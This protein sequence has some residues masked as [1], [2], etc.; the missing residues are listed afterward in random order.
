MHKS[1][2]SVSTDVRLNSTCYLIMKT[3][4]KRELQNITSKY[5]ADID[6]KDIMKIYRKHTS[7]PY[8]FLKFDTTLL[9]DDPLRFRTNLL[10]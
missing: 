10:D 6:Y 7:K 2:F 4:N 1:Y 3:H 5:L 9:T 8:S